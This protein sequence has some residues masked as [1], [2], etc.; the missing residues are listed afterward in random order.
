MEVKG[1]MAKEIKR[2]ILSITI[3]FM[4]ILFPIVYASLVPIVNA[5]EPTIKDKTLAILTDVVGI[6]TEEYTTDQC[7]QYDNNYRNLPQKEADMTL[8]SDQGR[9]RARCS[10]VNNMLRQIFL[11]DYEGE[12]A[13]KQSAIATADMAKSFLQGY[14]NYAGDSFYGELASTLDNVDVSTN[15]TISA[16]KIKLEVLNWDQTILDYVWTFADANGIVAESKNVILSYD[17]GQ[18]RVFLNNWPLY[19]VMGAPKVSSEE[20]TA[21]G[22]DASKNFSYEVEIDNVTSTITGFK[23]ASES[24]GHAKLSYLNF[25]NQSLARGGDP[26]TLYPSW[27]VPLGFD[28][29]YPGGV[30]GMTVS[31]WAD[32]GDVSIMGPMVVD[33]SSSNIDE[34]EKS[35][36]SA[37]AVTEEGFSQESPASAPFVA[38]AAFTV[39]GVAIITAK[40]TNSGDR[41]PFKKFWMTLLCGVILSSVILTAVPTTFAVYPSP[42][43]KARI[44]AALDGGQG[45]PPQL[46][47]EKDAANWICGEIA[48]AFTASGYSTSNQAGS[49]TSKYNILINA[50]NDEQAYDRVALFHFG[51]M[52][53]FNVGY[54]DNSGEQVLHTDIRTQT[55]DRKHFFVF[56]WACAQANHHAW[57]TPAAWT[58]RGDQTLYPLYDLP[59]LSSNGYVSP[60]GDGQ[61][62]IGF[63]GASPIISGYHQTFEQEMTDP[64]KYFIESFY[65]YALRTG[66]SIKSSLNHATLDFFGTTFTSSYLNTGFD[67]WFDGAYHDGQMRVF[68]DGNIKPCQPLLT[69]SARDNYNNQLYPT[70]YIGGVPVGTGSIRILSGT[71]TFN[72]NSI[73]GYTFDHFYCDYGSSSHSD[74]QTPPISQPIDHDC[75]LTAYYQYN[76]PSRTLTISVNGNG[77][78]TP[79]GTPQYPDGYNTQVL[80]IPD[81][82]NTLDHWLLDGQNVGAQ[83]PIT[84]TMNSDHSLQANF[85]GPP[86]LSLTVLATNQYS[87]PG[88]VPLYIDDEYV[89]LTGDTYLVSDGSH[90]IEVPDIISDYMTYYHDFQ[91]YYYDGNYNYNNEMTLS[92]TEDKTITAYHYSSYA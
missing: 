78:T 33:V 58:H 64:L 13:V 27:Y 10:F 72:I 30:T 25:P 90:T 16:G 82:G 17:Q 46:Q 49:G 55:A 53:D 35:A 44:Y 20:A 89:G 43:S 22:L 77:Y 54:V 84:V 31:I 36:I 81:P 92:I 62:Y 56:I 9:V 32:T 76:N 65:D 42:N 50:E 57:G 52:A 66:Y 85:D 14:Q 68:G 61:A 83:N 34:E 37:E 39:I 86:P 5:A 23:I 47:D 63:S 60:D 69:V 67:A 70:F 73:S 75:V 21:I 41:K 2:K 26:F 51:H 8:I 88:Y 28:K 24:L 1:K 12:L 71:Y 7:S 48:S 45:S 87:Q 18:L 38:V 4:L 6:N 59:F 80:A 3:L 11:S 74:Y 91:Y 15:I 79:S 40:K 19:K 29:S